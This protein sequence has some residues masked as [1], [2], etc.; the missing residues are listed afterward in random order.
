[1]EGDC[2]TV[3]V[4]A[5]AERFRCVGV[6]WFEQQ[7]EGARGGDPEITS[8]RGENAARRGRRKAE[9]IQ[10]RILGGRDEGKKIDPF[11]Q[12]KSQSQKCRVG[13]TPEGT[14]PRR[15]GYRASGTLAG[16]GKKKCEKGFST[17]T[18]NWGGTPGSKKFAK[19]RFG[20]KH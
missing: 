2:C 8:L 14:K 16:R 1:M 11:L 17:S 15:Q 20:T 9:K 12:K 7:R 6:I 3:R 19:K 18:I 4:R 13:K 10:K 5:L